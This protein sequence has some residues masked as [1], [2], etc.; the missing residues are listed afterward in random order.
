MTFHYRLLLVLPALFCFYAMNSVA[1]TPAAPPPP[2]AIPADVSPLFV[3]TYVEAMPTARDEAAALLKSYRDASRAA[4]GNMRSLVVQRPRRPGQFV[5]VAAWKDKS[6]WDAHS[7]APATKEFR[8][9]LNTLRA[10]PADDR[11]HNAL[12]NGPLDIPQATPGAVYVVSHVDAIGARKDDAVA[13][14][15]VMAEASRKANGSVH[16]EVV[17]QTNRPN[18]FTVFE[19]WR[20]REAFDAQATSAHGREFRD[21]LASM[22]GALYDERLYEILN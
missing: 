6:A 11:F 17:Q 2:P 21:K 9:K 8:D 4:A 13:A 3:V 5:I 15:K 19:V 14:L 7:A 10:V 12:A 20:S 16:Y 18:H 22:I 1:Q